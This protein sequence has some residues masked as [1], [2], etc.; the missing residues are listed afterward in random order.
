MKS[1]YIE[2][3]VRFALITAVALI[4]AILARTNIVRDVSGRLFSWVESPL[5]VVADET[6][7]QGEIVFASRKELIAELQERET[8][9]LELAQTAAQ[10]SQAVHE[11]DEALALLGYTEQVTE[12][13]LAARV[14]VRAA[15]TDSDSVIIDKGAVDGVAAQQAVVT[16]DGVLYGLVAEV[17]ANTARVVRVTDPSVVVGGGLLDVKSTVGVVEGGHGPVV[18]MAFVAQDTDVEVNDVIVTSGVDPQIPAGIVI[19]LVNVIEA[20]P[21]APFLT[22]FVEPLAQLQRARVVGV[23]LSP[24]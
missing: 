24:L 18:R 22:L 10:W 3:G 2:W 14:R 13:I 9:V 17:F 23:V 4:L 6:T 8:Q 5:T 11:R 7:E 1:A 19:G 12:P 20:D 21:N 16:Q 15:E